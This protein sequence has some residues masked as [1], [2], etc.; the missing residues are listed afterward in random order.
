MDLATPTFW[1]AV[2]TLVVAALTLFVTVPIAKWTRESR[3]VAEKALQESRDASKLADERYLLSMRP[4][5]RVEVENEA[6][7]VLRCSYV[8]AGA[9]AVD[10]ICLIHSLEYLFVFHFPVP[11]QY[12][13]N[14]SFP[15]QST[16][17]AKEFGLL[18]P[19]VLISIA[20]SVDGA[21][22]DLLTGQRTDLNDQQALAQANT[23]LQQAAQ[24]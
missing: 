1:V 9:A 12:T 5:P 18:G 2:A 14:V 3:T 21:W 22:W 13:H 17:K 20:K 15:Q 6:P 8:N 7:G 11:A 19:T 24:Q 10:W 16:I 4:S 23:V